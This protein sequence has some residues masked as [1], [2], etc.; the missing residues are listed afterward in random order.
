M[1]SANSSP[2]RIVILDGSGW[3]STPLVASPPIEIGTVSALSVDPV[4]EMRTVEVA[5]PFSQRN[6]SRAAM[7]TTLSV[8]TLMIAL[9][10]SEPEVAVIV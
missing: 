4:R 6:S 5:L 8:A 3:K 10:V 1:S 7:L 9:S 2:A